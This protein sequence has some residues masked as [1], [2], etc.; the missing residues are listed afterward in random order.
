MPELGLTKFCMLAGVG[1]VDV[2]SGEKQTSEWIVTNQGKA[3]TGL[4]VIVAGECI[5][6]DLLIPELVKVGLFRNENISSVQF[7][8][9]VSTEGEKIFYAKLEDF[10][11]P[12]GYK[13]NYPM[14]PK[15]SKRYGMIKYEREVNFSI[16]FLGSKEGTG[17]FTVYFSPLVNRQE[18][19][20]YSTSMKGTLEDWKKKNAL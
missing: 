12:E 4:D 11:I 18:G 8:E 16:T 9:A 5:T 15:E 2:K 14:T 6:N 10:I 13:P 20:D 3:S 7:I 17:E 1:I 19:G